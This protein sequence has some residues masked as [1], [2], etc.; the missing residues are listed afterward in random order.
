MS[1]NASGFVQ[2]LS[3]DGEAVGLIPGGALGEVLQVW[4]SVH[5]SR[6]IMRVRLPY[7]PGH[8]DR[9]LASVLLQA[10][11]QPVLTRNVS[12]ARAWEVIASQWRKCG[13]RLVVIENAN[14]LDRDSLAYVNRSYLP[15]V[16]LVGGERLAQQ[17]TR[18]AAYARCILEWEV[19]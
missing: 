17:I 16:I 7:Q 10:L 13:C 5:G 11:G 8:K 2:T 6:G 15:A 4:E 1:E 3:N 14:L 9:Q 19:V 18:D 12:T